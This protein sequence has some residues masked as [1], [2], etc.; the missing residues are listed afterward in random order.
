MPSMHRAAEG[1]DSMVG[2]ASRF[3]DEDIDCSVGCLGSSRICGRRSGAQRVERGRT[4]RDRQ[5][6]AHVG[7][8]A[9]DHRCAVGGDQAAG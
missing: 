9:R 7:N 6:A 3:V 2:S 4:G 5:V 8:R 1:L